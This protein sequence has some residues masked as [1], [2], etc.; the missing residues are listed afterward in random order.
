ME[1]ETSTVKNIHLHNEKVTQ[2]ILESKDNNLKRLVEEYVPPGFWQTPS[3]TQTY[4][5]F[6]N[7]ESCLG[8]RDCQ[9]GYSG[10]LCNECLPQNSNLL[11]NK[12]NECGFQSISAVLNEL[13]VTTG[14]VFFMW[15]I[16]MIIID[17]RN[18]LDIRR[19]D[20]TKRQKFWMLVND[21]LSY[22]QDMY[23]LSFIEPN[24]P[25]SLLYIT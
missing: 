15:C 19:G 7:P 12:C 4:F 6:N 18:S 1:R 21:I 25:T 24:L 2:R 8:E 22:L 23:L 17:S 14:P 9:E 10:T 16:L 11:K 3:L 20:S 13:F 5:C